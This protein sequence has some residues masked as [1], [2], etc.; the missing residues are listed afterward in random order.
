[1]AGQTASTIIRERWATDLRER[2]VAEGHDGRRVDELIA[3][4]LAGFESAHIR[5]FI[6]LLVTRSVRDALR[7]R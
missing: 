7:R 4:D 5:D 1:V 3:S 6:P 2:L